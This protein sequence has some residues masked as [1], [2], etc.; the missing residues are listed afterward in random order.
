MPR[1][2]IGAWTW[3]RRRRRLGFPLLRWSLKEKQDDNA[4]QPFSHELLL[5]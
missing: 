4:D 1:D 5:N 2:R 3:L